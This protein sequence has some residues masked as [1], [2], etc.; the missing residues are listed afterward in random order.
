M[1]IDI[2]VGDSAFKAFAMS[3]RVNM[4]IPATRT[5]FEAI[6]RT[7]KLAHELFSAWLNTTRR[8]KHINIFL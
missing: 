8:L 5:L 4:S 1:I 3:I 2:G 6:Q 7:S